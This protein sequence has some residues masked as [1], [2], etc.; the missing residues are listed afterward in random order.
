VPNLSKIASYI[1]V[2]SVQLLQKTKV[3]GKFILSSFK[4]LHKVSTSISNSIEGARDTKIS[5]LSGDTPITTGLCND[6]LSLT[7]SNVARVAVAV[8]AIILISLD[9]MLRRSPR[10]A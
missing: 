5:G 3:L 10:E 1:S 6:N 2:H 7:I 9:I 8:S 4:P